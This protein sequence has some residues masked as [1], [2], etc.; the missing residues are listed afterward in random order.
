VTAPTPSSSP[1]TTS[2]ATTSSAT[3]SSAECKASHLCK[4][5]GQCTAKD[6]GCVV[7]SVADCVDVPHCQTQSCFAFDG[8]CRV[9]D[10]C[11]CH[12]PT[13]IPALVQKRLDCLVAAKIPLPAPCNLP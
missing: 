13:S 1:T 10:P 9:V 3:T 7:A 12:Y 6:G 11:S 4:L 5:T 2:S 8:S